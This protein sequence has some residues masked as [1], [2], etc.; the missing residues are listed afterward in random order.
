ME[1]I[2]VSLIGLGIMLGWWLRNV[3]LKLSKPKTT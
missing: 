3:A 2:A 1:L